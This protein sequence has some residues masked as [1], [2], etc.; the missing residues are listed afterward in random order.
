MARAQI[1]FNQ[2]LCV[3]GQGNPKSRDEARRG[4]KDDRPSTQTLPPR[5]LRCRCCLLPPGLLLMH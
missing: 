2:W 5:R 4:A 3:D 1:A